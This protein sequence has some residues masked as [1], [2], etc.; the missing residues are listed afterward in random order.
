MMGDPQATLCLL[1]LPPIGSA[2]LSSTPFCG[3]IEV[4]LRLAGLEY[5]TDLG[6]F[7]D[8]KVIPKKKVHRRNCSG[9]TRPCRLSK[10]A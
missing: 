2:V 6:D 3:K 5:T 7:N 10:A 9:M 4:A 8:K 1:S